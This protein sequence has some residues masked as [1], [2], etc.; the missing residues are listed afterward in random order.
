MVRCGVSRHHFNRLHTGVCGGC[1]CVWWVCV[2]VLCVVWCVGECVRPA[3]RLAS[4]RMIINADKIAPL[5]C[6]KCH[7]LVVPSRNMTCSLVYGQE[8]SF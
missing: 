2:C 3:G 4:I 5:K 7:H 8:E 1:V 6:C